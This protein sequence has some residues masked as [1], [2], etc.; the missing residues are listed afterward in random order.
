MDYRYEYYPK[1]VSL[2]RIRQASVAEQKLFIPLVDRILAAK[3]ENAAAD[4]STW[5]REIDQ[6]VYSFY[7]LTEEEIKIVE[8]KSEP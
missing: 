3:A 1:P 8:G 5:E 4:V 6:L 2:L 7:G